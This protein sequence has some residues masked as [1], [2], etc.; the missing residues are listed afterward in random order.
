MDS[1][2]ESTEQRE[3]T[4]EQIEA[5]LE[6]GGK[7]RP[8]K[9][10]T[11]TPNTLVMFLD[12]ANEIASAVNSSAEAPLL[13]TYKE[14]VNFL[15]RVIQQGAFERCLLE[16]EMECWRKRCDDLLFNDIGRRIKKLSYCPE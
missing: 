3:V 15:V 13:E 7:V 16:E 8:A 1:N 10:V 11:Q 14:Q 5:A 2:Q 9:Q 4:E 12:R 6:S